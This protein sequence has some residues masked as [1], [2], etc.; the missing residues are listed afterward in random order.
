MKSVLANGTD[1]SLLQWFKE[2]SA[3][4][5]SGE[6]IRW[7]EQVLSF[8]AFV[9][10]IDIIQEE[11]S[12]LKLPRGSVLGLCMH[13]SPDWLTGYLAAIELG[14]NTI[15]LNPKFG[16]GELDYIDGKI[17][18]DGWI[19]NERSGG[20]TVERFLEKKRKSIYD[21]R[22]LCGDRWQLVISEQEKK[23]RIDSKYPAGMTIF[24]TSGTTSGPKLV[25]HTQENMVKHLGSIGQ[26]FQM[27]RESRFIGYLPL[28]GIFGLEATLGILL[29]G[30]A[31]ALFDKFDATDI[32]RHIISWKATHVLG[33]CDLLGVVFRGMSKHELEMT[34]K[35]VKYVG[36][37]S[38]TSG[39]SVPFG[40]WAWEQSIPVFG[41]YGSSEVH[42]LFATRSRSDPLPL[43]LIGG[44]IPCDPDVKLRVRVPEARAGAGEGE[45]SES[46]EIKTP[47]GF[48]EYYGDPDKTARV[49]TED[50]YIRSG[51][52]ATLSDDGGFTFHGRADDVIRLGGFLTSPA[53]IENRI[54]EIKGVAEAVVVPVTVL[55]RGSCAAF[56]KPHPDATVTGKDIQKCLEQRIATFKVP[57]FVWLISEIPHTLGA[58]G[59]KY[60]RNELR[61]LAEKRIEAPED[62]SPDPRS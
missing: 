40:M 14:Y 48:V 51:D 42:A 33:D 58:N 29:N 4:G 7:Q 3:T 35:S 53:E 38:F 6:A 59:K 18:V 28:C 15:L 41:L 19:I 39:D 17:R 26:P 8:Q 43:R 34:A 12:A 47:S 44:G 56:V 27:S 24:T 61:H 9:D 55:G 50:G 2:V 31:V 37:G 23:K 60:K 1:R 20:S 13:N 52:S 57:K 21:L 54:M 11:L 5:G 45:E 62:P 10:Q 16:T 36:S 22:S 49:R 25:M 30:G 46:L 32:R